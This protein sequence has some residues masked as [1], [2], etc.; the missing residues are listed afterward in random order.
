MRKILVVLLLVLSGSIQAAVQLKEDHPDRYTVVKGDTLWGIAQRFLKKPWEWPQIWHVNPK[1]QNPHLIYPGDVLVLSY[2]DGQPKV[3][4]ERA[5]SRGTIKLSPSVRVQPIAEAIPTIPL[6]A[7]SSFLL[8]NRI[9]DSLEELERAPYVLAGDTQRVV[10]GQGDRIYARGDFRQAIPGYRVF[11]QGKS[12]IDPETQELLGVNLDDIAS[13]ELVAVDGP[14]ASLGLTRVTQEVRLGDRLL[15]DEERPLNSAFMPSAPEQRVDGVILDVPR[16]VTQI[17]LM[18]VVILNKGS[19]N[20]LKEGHVL[21][22]YKKGESVLDRLT[23]E[24]IKVPDERAGLLM[25]FRT[26]E[27]LSYG[28]VLQASRS[29]SLQDRVRNP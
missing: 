22:V 19:R 3:D 13:A 7:I 10:S 21:A 11:R 4:L 29:L 2:V 25:V 24:R 5:A 17:G 14:I 6:S 8:G 15:P 16:G 12:H 26:Y 18:D 23:G 28:L 27:K 1:V 20:G 9:L